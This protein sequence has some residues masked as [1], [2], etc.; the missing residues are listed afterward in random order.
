MMVARLVSVERGREGERGSRVTRVGGK[1][2]C[3]GGNVGHSSGPPV[4]PSSV[5]RKEEE[6][7]EKALRRRERERDRTVQSELRLAESGIAA[8][9]IQE[10]GRCKKRN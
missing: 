4:V 3:G 7:E 10:R 6:E 8:Q 2:G 5:G 1:E 9:L